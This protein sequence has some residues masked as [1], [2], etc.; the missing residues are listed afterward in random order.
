[1]KTPKLTLIKEDANKYMIQLQFFDERAGNIDFLT[2]YPYPM[3]RAEAEYRLARIGTA[4]NFD[5]PGFL[6]EER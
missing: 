4:F 2:S 1:M 3:T 6:V 5:L